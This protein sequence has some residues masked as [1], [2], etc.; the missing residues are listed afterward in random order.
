MSA[1]EVIINKA[2]ELIDRLVA[3][4]K[5]RLGEIRNDYEAFLVDHPVDEPKYGTYSFGENSPYTRM[6][7]FALKSIGVE[8]YL[9][10]RSYRYSS[11]HKIESE[12]RLATNEKQMDYYLK[13][14]REANRVKLVR[15]IEKYVTEEMEVKGDVYVTDGVKGVE[16]SAIV[17]FGDE[18]KRFK[19]RAIFAGGYIQRYHYRYRGGL[20][21]V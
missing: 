11:A 10:E 14:Y 9:T 16:V 12:V 7:Q 3:K 5:S 6:G 21:A 20:V 2:E 1:K 19:T 15:A 13:N 4:E 18:V 17:E 8:D